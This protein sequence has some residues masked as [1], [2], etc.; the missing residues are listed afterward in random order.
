MLVLG[1]FGLL[2]KSELWGLRVSDVKVAMF[3]GTKLVSIFV[4]RSKNDPAGKG[5]AVVLK[6]TTGSGVNIAFVVRK[7]LAHLQG[8]SSDGPLFQKWVKGAWNGPYADS[9]FVIRRLQLLHKRL[10]RELPSLGIGRLKITAHSLRVGGASWAEE[11]GVPL[12]ALMTHG[13]W[14][15][16]A[17]SVYCVRA[18]TDRL[19]VSERM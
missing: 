1:F 16:D 4:K 10:E 12:P 15:S 18:L 2:R 19:K 14:K 9:S 7:H 8:Q 5:A 6:G 13:R 3:T 11:K 17:V